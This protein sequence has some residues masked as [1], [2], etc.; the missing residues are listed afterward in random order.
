MLGENILPSYLKTVDLGNNFNQ[1]IG[2]NVLPNS[3]KTINFGCNFNQSIGENVLPSSLES[4]NFGCKFNQPI[5]ENILPN[6]LKTIEFGWKFNQPIGENVLPNSL[7]TIKFRCRFNQP[8]GE[9]IL[10]AS[11]K[12]VEI[13][14]SYGYFESGYDHSIS[15]LYNLDHLK[16]LSIHT[17]T[18]IEIDVDRLPSSLKYLSTSN[19]DIALSP[20]PESQRM[21]FSVILINLQRLS[22]VTYSILRELPYGYIGKYK[23]IG[24][25]TIDGIK[26]NILINPEYYQPRSNAKSARK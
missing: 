17:E 24:S 7:K 10:P 3:L 12:R 20:N 18:D 4:I 14:D 1:P 13:G 21:W 22:D 23:V 11:I 6:Y 9:N 8:I 26:Y 2:E 19:A 16:H 25:D 5:G 15:A